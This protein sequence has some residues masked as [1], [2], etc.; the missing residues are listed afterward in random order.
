[1]KTYTVHADYHAYENSIIERLKL[2]DLVDSTEFDLKEAWINIGGWQSWNPAFEIAPGQEQPSLT[3]KFIKGW[4]NY[5][6][7]P[8]STYT[9]DKNLL[10]AQF[11]SYLRWGD[12]YLVFASVGNLSRV[13]HL[14]NLFLTADRIQSQLKFA[15]KETTGGAMILQPR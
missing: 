10:L 3:N 6:V 2:S 9:P 7:F 12:F 8:N 15:T 1:M 5:L 14:F 11:I 4:N 13:L